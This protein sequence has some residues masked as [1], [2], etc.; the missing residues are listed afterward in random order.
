[1]ASQ[2]LSAATLL[3]DSLKDLQA[4]VISHLCPGPVGNSPEGRDDRNPAKPG[5]LQIPAQSRFL[6]QQASQSAIFA[7]RLTASSMRS[8]LTVRASLT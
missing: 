1:M 5:V 7:M 6:F 8:L 3:K 2:S 4:L